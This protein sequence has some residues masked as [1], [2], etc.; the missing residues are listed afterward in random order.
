M[1][2][3]RNTVAGFSW[4][5][6]L[7]DQSCM[8]RSA[9]TINNFDRNTICV[10]LEGRQKVEPEVKSTYKVIRRSIWTVRSACK[11]VG[12]SIRTIRSAWKVV[13]RSIRTVRSAWKVVRRSIRTVRSA[14]KVVR[15][16]IQAVRSAWRSS[17]GRS[18]CFAGQARAGQGR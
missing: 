4:I 2:A 11:A 8:L 10:G 1:W 13:R 9:N 14:W 16:S 3:R 7:M 12:R 17:E 15:C 6:C 5:R 18:G